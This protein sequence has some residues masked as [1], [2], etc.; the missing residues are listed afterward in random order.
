MK[1]LLLFLLG[2]FIL[3]VLQGGPH[4][5]N[6]VSRIDT[7]LHSFSAAKP[8]AVQLEP[9]NMFQQHRLR[10]KALNDYHELFLFVAS[11]RIKP[12]NFIYSVPVYKGYKES[13][14]SVA[15]TLSDWRGPPTA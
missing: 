14:I 15:V 4:V 5:A 8:R 11:I 2:I 10:T 7:V 1:R 13:Y 12:L 3:P 9:C 6:T